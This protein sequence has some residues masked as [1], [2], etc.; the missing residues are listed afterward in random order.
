MRSSAP[1]TTEGLLPPPAKL[2]RRADPGWSVQSAGRFSTNMLPGIEP[3]R[4]PWELSASRY[5][6][7]AAPD[8]YQAGFRVKETRGLVATCQ[9]TYQDPSE[10]IARG[11]GLEQFAK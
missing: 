9:V 7:G 8:I 2:S 11:S 5:L 1:N 6:A 3:M 4:P 10:E